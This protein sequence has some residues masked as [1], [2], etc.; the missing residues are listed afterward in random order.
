MAG[1]SSWPLLVQA[2]YT[3]PLKKKPGRVEYQRGILG[4]PL[5]RA[6][7]PPDDRLIRLAIQ[8]GST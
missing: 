2:R 6:C 5:G 3:K 4:P 7:R 1:E 8:A